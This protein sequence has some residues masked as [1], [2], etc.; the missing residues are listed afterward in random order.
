MDR[1]KK[2]AIIQARMGSSR[3]PGKVLMDLCGETALARV[4]HRLRHANLVDE[5]VV[6]TSTSEQDDAVVRE[7]E[8]LRILFFRGSEH[9]VLDRYYRC[10]EMNG[11]AVVVRITADCPL[12]DPELVDLTI[13]AF[14]AETCDYASNGLVATYPR[15]LDVEVFT[16]VALARAWSEAHST[17]E[18]EHVTPYLYEHPE[19][20]RLASVKAD[21][22][23]SHHRWT[24]DTIEDL[25]LSRSIYAR[26][27]NQSC[28]S[29]REVLEVVQREPQLALINA[30]VLQKAVDA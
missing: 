25:E 22:D 15:G 18:R 27:K 30:H 4:I 17:Y 8:R 23:Y 26:F 21:A 3:L 28:F 19:L 9:D 20:F 24:L 2:L 11:G 29:W 7:C 10:A 1:A 5:I 16:R 6:A 12:I 14:L 13:R